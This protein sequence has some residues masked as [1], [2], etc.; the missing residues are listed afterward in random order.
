M[1]VELARHLALRLGQ[2]VVS[3]EP[4]LQ[5]QTPSVQNLTGHRVSISRSSQMPD[6]HC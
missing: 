4:M 3:Q 2:Q 1:H 6:A 5:L